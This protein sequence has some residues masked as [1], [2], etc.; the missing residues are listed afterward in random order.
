[1]NVLWT[2]L[3]A[4]LAQTGSTASVE[5]IVVKLG[6]GEPLARATVTLWNDKN[7][8]A[9]LS[10]TTGADGRFT[11]SNVEPGD[12]R[13]QASHPGPYMPADY[14]QSKPTRRGS[15]ITIRAG[16]RI[17]GL[18]LE[19]A[20]TSSISGRILD[21]DGEPLGR[22]EVQALQ[23]VYDEGR[24]VLRIVQSIMTNDLGEY[25]LRLRPPGRYYI[26]A[27]MQN[28]NQQTGVVFVRQS[29]DPLRFYLETLVPYI[30]HRALENGEVEDFV[31]VPVYFP[32]TIDSEMAEPL[33]IHIGENR[34]GM[35]FT[36]GSGHR[37]AHRIRGRITSST[38][39]PVHNA[40]LVVVPRNADFK[41]IPGEGPSC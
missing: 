41:R 13:L 28:P 27:R 35:D 15:L 10:A 20:P 29:Q 4:L 34:S 38:G 19:L 40:A 36:V 18:R 9:V 5:G 1:M 25:R 16:Q 22:V 8:R 12:Y 37:R 32:G 7:V 3:F 30:S 14:G 11:I 17:T 24:K 6:S 21:S 23:P 31:D 2:V 33:E 39:Q 26:R